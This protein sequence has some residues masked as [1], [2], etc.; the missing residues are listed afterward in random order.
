MKK[1]YLTTAEEVGRIARRAGAAI[2]DVYNSDDFGVET[3]DDD[4]PLTRADRAANEV[5]VAGL[6]QLS[7]QAP[8]VSE[9]GKD[10]PYA[11]R[12]QYTRF[13]LV[14]PLDG[15]KEFIKRNGEFTVNIALI[16]NGRPVLGAVYIPVSDELYYA[17]QSEGAWRE[18]GERIQAAS[19]TMQDANLRVVASRSHLNEA[20]QAFMDRLNEPEIV[21][22]G[23]SLKILELARGAA[24][25]YPR[26]APT[27]EW[28][29]AAAHAI[30]LEAGGRLVD[31]GTGKELVY[32]K[33]VLRNP[34][35]VAYGKVS[36]G[37]LS[38]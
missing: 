27:M 25:L 12:R 34:H 36:E 35:F 26:L 32:N 38:C 13:W 31:D 20:T 21:S 37:Q 19:F 9:E 16:E 14:D 17:A 24:H 8:I 15:T 23:S 7:L 2:L 18:G 28:D 30:L 33:E 29:T 22:R 11:E 3:K 1:S 10:I 4:S 6:R 5:I